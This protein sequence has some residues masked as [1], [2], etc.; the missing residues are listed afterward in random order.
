MLFGRKQE[1]GASLSTI[2]ADYLIIGSITQFG[3]KIPERAEFFHY[4]NA[5]R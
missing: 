5:N 4:E 1:R 2:G 3:R